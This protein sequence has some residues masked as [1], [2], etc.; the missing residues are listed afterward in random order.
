MPLLFRL[1]ALCLALR[2]PAS[3]PGKQ[4]FIPILARVVGLFTNKGGIA[5][6]VKA[7]KLPQPRAK[8]F[9]ERIHSVYLLLNIV[10]MAK[11]A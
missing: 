6:R 3:N 4:L 8:I 2:L 10:R 7:E 11:S 9:V 1:C 5:L